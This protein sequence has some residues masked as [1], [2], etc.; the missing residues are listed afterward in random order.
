[1]LLGLTV[2]YTSDAF[3]AR[4]LVLLDPTAACR[5]YIWCFWA[6]RWAIHLVLSGLVAGYTSG[7]FGAYGGLYI[8]CFRDFW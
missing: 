3:G 6:L 4:D 7:A 1:M 5:L 8:W 2:G